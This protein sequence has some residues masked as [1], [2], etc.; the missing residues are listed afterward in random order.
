MTGWQRW[1]LNDNLGCHKIDLSDRKIKFQLHSTVESPPRKKVLW[2]TATNYAEKFPVFPLNSPLP[3]YWIGTLGQV[4]FAV[5]KYLIPHYLWCIELRI[6]YKLSEWSGRNNCGTRHSAIGL[7]SLQ[8]R[9]IN[10]IRQRQKAKDNEERRLFESL[11]QYLYHHPWVIV[12][13]R[14]DQHLHHGVESRICISS[15]SLSL[16]TVPGVDDGRWSSFR[17]WEIVCTTRGIVRNC[18]VLLCISRRRVHF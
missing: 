5:I 14:I 12:Y 9:R 8:I 18:K 16:P 4:I 17:T 10:K 13:L 6:T 3:S 15:H 1:Y 11:S 7:I 2:R